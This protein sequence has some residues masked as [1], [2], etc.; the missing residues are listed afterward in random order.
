MIKAKNF[1]DYLI[2]TIKDMP[3]IK[4]IIVENPD[5]NGPFGAKSIGEPTLELGSAAIAN[6]V[7]HASG[8]RIRSLPLNLERVLIGRSLHK[9][10]K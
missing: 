6:A 4:P 9:G 3:E 8:R 5:P 1:H 2:P 10:G 7:A